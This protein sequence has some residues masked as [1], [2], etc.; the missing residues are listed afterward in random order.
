MSFPDAVDNQGRWFKAK[1]GDMYKS[2]VYS[3]GNVKW[4]PEGTK[5]S[6]GPPGG[7]IT[8]VY[9]LYYTKMDQF[10][11]RLRGGPLEEI[12]DGKQ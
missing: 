11:E 7:G 1:N 3:S 6:A 10:I 2:I 5:I 8:H 12:Y 4:K 9:R